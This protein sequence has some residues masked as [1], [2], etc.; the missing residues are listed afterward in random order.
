MAEERISAIQN[1]MSRHRD[2]HP[3][4]TITEA[5]ITQT[6]ASSQSGFR[7]YCFGSA[8]YAHAMTAIATNAESNSSHENWRFPNSLRRR[9]LNSPFL[10]LHEFLLFNS[11][12]LGEVTPT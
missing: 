11:V 4:V 3:T 9:T 7:W 6:A 8:R 10:P 5:I 1:A 2:L 12:G